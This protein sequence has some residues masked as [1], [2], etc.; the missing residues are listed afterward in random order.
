MS[1]RDSLDCKPKLNFELLR[2][3]INWILKGADFSAICWRSDCT[4]GTPR[5]LAIV[6]LLWS[7]SD[8]SLVGDRFTTARRIALAMFPQPQAVANTFQGFIKL[9]RKWTGG[10]LSTL[11]NVFR[12]RMQEDF[13]D[14]MKVGK[15]VIYGVDG[16]RI[17]LART[18]A[19][20]QAF[21][22]QRKN[23]K[24]KT[25]SQK[26]KQYASQ[27]DARKANTVS[28]W[29][30]V[31]WHLGSGLPWDW[32]LG[33]SD[34]SERAHWL[35][36]MKGI[37]ERALFVA[38]AGFVG[39]EYSS[40]AISAGHQVLLRVGSNVT[41]LKK[42]GYYAKEAEGI[43]YL[44]PSKAAKK[45]QPPLVC[46][47]I[48]AHNGKHPIYLI[49]SILST[50]DLSDAQALEIYKRRWGIELFYR[51][52]KQT[53]EMHKLK[54]TSPESGMVELNWALLGL[55]CMALYALKELRRKGIDPN[56]LS[57]AKLIRAF[58]RMLRDY[59]HP[60]ER[61]K[62]LCDLLGEAV[63]DDYDRSN[64]SKTSRKYPRKK[65]EK[66]PGA[67]KIQTATQSQIQLAKQLE[68]PEKIRFTA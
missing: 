49:T 47:L 61:D 43:V 50:K 29:I 60:I 57:F 2:L 48:V 63:I 62:K 39:Y 56:R 65:N 4:W 11:Q 68:Q 5:L 51:H 17:N 6:A 27:A 20:E 19:N 13:A 22:P 58:R 10:L 55:W 46:R 41:L 45:K 21:S 14:L 36:M 66:P 3:A 18:K 38:D 26:K 52:L 35:E 30:T 1:H 44:W 23:K 28:I 37:V 9:L 34:S 64:S 59:L 31:L 12:K 25:K 54:S 7:W 53:Y 8:E 42:L 32:R 67:P 15:W 40:A 24:G 16:S 33:P